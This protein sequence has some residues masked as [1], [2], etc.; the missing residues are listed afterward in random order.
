MSSSTEAVSG[1]PVYAAGVI[2]SFSLALILLLQVL[3]VFDGGEVSLLEGYRE[4]GF[5]LESG[6]AQPGWGLWLIGILVYVLP[7]AL[8]EIPG[9]PKRL[10]VVGAMLVLLTLT[11]PVL[12]LWQVYWNPMSTLLAAG[13]AGLCSLL[14]AWQHPMPCES[15]LL[16]ESQREKIIALDERE[17]TRRKQS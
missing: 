4:A 16:D 13:W 9:T 15:E 10:L 17:E 3:G 1:H 2:G 14:W 7:W 11:S 8:F 12:A 6:A 5:L